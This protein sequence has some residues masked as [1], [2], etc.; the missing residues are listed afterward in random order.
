M[1]PSYIP[2]FDKLNITTIENLLLKK[3]QIQV[4]CSQNKKA[5]RI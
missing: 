5:T 3:N 1:Q 4:N 2:D